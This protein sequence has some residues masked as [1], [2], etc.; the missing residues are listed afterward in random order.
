MPPD[1]DFLTFKKLISP[2][3]NHD[4]I[5]FVRA[6]L[7]YGKYAFSRVYINCIFEEDLYIFKEKFDDYI[8]LN[9]N[10]K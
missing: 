1:L 8:F 3:P 9:S 6:D 2:I 7:S 10:G 5:Y 4:Y